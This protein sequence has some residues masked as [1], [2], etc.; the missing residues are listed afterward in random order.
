MAL[1][2]RLNWLG[3]G[4]AP[5][6]NLFTAVSDDDAAATVAAAWQQGIRFFDT[7]PQYGHGLSETRLGAALAEYPRDEYTLVSKVGRILVAPSPGAARPPSGFVDIPAVDPVFDFSRDG[8]LRSLDDSLTRLDTD[9]L[10]IV[11]VHDPDDHEAEA[12]AAA[13]PT[14]IELRNQGVIGQVGCGMNQVA[15]LAR[16]VEQ[17]DLDCILLAGRYTLLDRSGAPLLAL[18]E[19]LGIDVI[20]G[21]VFNSGL[22][23]NPVVGATFDYAAAPPELVARAQALQAVCEEFLVP[24]PA[25]ALQFV[26]RHSAVARTLVGARA[27]AEIEADVAYADLDIPDEL[28]GELEALTA[29]W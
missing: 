29:R 22:L 20:V 17:V 24:L 23:A 11:H 28:W 14:L 16:F 4:C 2:R 27:A 9:R 13:F 15:M 10:D 1:N 5:L 21:G 8:I 26:S 25:A 7:A 19:S 12:L 6:G 18:C 3:L